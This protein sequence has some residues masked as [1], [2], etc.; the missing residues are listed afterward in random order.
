M[1]T[2]VLEGKLNDPAYEPDPVFQMMVPTQ[3]PGV[4]TLILNPRNT[5]SDKEGYDAM[6]KNLAG[7]FI[8]NFEKYA[9]G[10]DEAIIA[11]APLSC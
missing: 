10:V 7:Q 3:C 6:A 1:I 8:K 5:W 9:A 2:A 11:A 4:P